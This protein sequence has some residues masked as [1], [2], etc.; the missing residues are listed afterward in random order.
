MR[1][2]GL[3]QFGTPEQ[4]AQAEA[5]LAALWLDRYIDRALAAGVDRATR[6][7]LAM[8][9]VTGGGVE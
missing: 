3:K 5:E 4:V 9:L 7:R 8:K 6:Q 2:S 1:L